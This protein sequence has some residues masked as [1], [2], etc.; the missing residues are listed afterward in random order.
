MVVVFTRVRLSQHPAQGD[1]LRQ[2]PCR[3]TG[4]VELRVKKAELVQGVSQVRSVPAGMGCSQLAAQR[5]SFLGR[6]HGVT[7][8]A[9]LP[10][11]QAELMQRLGHAGIVLAGV[12][13]CQLTARRNGLL[14]SD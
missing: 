7:G 13:R 5:D 11:Q 9:Q 8:A 4:T 12:S 6:S 2:G 10:L 14:S 1:G 3:L